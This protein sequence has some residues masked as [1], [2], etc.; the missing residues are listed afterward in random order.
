LK[1][2]GAKIMAKKIHVVINPASGQDQYILNT[3]NRVF[4]EAKIAW[5]VSITQTSG[6]ASRF[7]A[8]A[9]A[10]DADIVAV[11][12]GDGSVMEVAEGLIGTNIPLSILPGGTANLMSVELG[13]PRKLEDAARVACSPSSVVRQVD[14]GQTEMGKFMLRVGI[15]F[16]AEK[17]ILA[18]RD[19]K[20][21]YGL[22]AYTIAAFKA[23]GKTQVSSYHLNLDGEQVDTEGIACRVDNSSNVGIQGISLASGTDVSDGYL[24][25]LVWRDRDLDTLVSLAG[26]LADHETISDAFHHWRAREITIETDA[27]QSI[28]GD[29]EVWGNTPISIKVLPGAMRVLVPK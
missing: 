11:Y 13:I 16:P 29:G 12:G 17:V 6:D 10:G 22:A 21:K 24:D 9:A 1:H 5:E 18:D 15:G 4:R 8:K 7:A 28:Q 14:M 26:G 3:I 27:P 2:I 19:L 20:D 23:M 25:V